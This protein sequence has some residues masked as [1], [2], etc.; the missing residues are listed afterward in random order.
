MTDKDAIHY[1]RSLQDEV[2]PR[3]DVYYALQ[4]G[5]HA[6]QDREAEAIYLRRQYE[7]TIISMQDTI[8]HLEAS[9]DYIL[10]LITAK[11]LAKPR[12]LVVEIKDKDALDYIAEKL[13]TEKK[14]DG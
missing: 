3:G 2:E 6:I 8:R 10:S 1:L 12:Q 9:R 11:E 4:A 7:K 14:N 5:I 13:N